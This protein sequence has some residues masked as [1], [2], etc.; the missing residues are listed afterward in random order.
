MKDEITI[1]TTQAGGHALHVEI[2]AQAGLSIGFANTEKAGEVPEELDISPVA[3][4]MTYNV[5]YNPADHTKTKCGTQGSHSDGKYTGSI[6]V[7]AFSDAA[8]TVLVG[9]TAR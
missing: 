5:T 6:T 7:R 1:T 3:S 9:L 4:G 2:P 8:H